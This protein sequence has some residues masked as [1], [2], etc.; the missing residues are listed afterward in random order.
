MEN[1]YI[2]FKMKKIEL[3]KKKKN[4]FTSLFNYF[5]IK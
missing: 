3:H 2:I 1:K 5:V 4:T